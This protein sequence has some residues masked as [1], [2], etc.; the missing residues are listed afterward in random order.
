[1]AFPKGVIG[2]AAIRTSIV[3]GSRLLIQVGTLLLLTRI[4]GASQFGAFAALAAMATLLGML[5]TFGTH[6]TLIRDL[7]ID[8]SCRDAILPAALGTTASVSS[9]LFLIYVGLAT[10]WLGTLPIPIWVVLCIGLSEIVLLPFLTLVAAEFLAQGKTASSQVILTA[11]LL[12]RLAVICLV[13]AVQPSD[14]L[15]AYAPGHLVTTVLGIWLA[16]LMLRRPWP[17][18]SAWRLLSWKDWGDRGSF[19]FVNMTAVGAT[20]LDKALAPRMLSLDAAGIYAAASRAVT[21]LSLPIVAL[22]L[23]ALPRLFRYRPDGQGHLPKLILLVALIYGVAA[24][25]ALWQ[26]APILGR[27]FGDGYAG[28]ETNIRWLALA[29]PGMSLRIASANV[30]MSVGRPWLRVA[31]EFSG[32]I[33][34]VVLALL[35][36][37]SLSANGLAI[38]LAVSESMVALIGWTVVLTSLR[39]GGAKA[40][41]HAT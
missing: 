13:W 27:V 21:A 28:I 9:L 40:N 19:A 15:L 35:L 12:M 38:A 16:Y 20:E 22:M 8:P 18:P 23:S 14:P 26:L 37:R 32:L 1:M 41:V 29:V 2:R 36:V 3:L 4:L 39:G 17:L 33:L 5:S 24:A 7:S 34:F 25:I 6:L 31:L 30:L 10:V 11:P